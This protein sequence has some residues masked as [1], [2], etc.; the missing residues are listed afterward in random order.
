[1]MSTIIPFARKPL[2]SD[3]SEKDIEQAIAAG[4]QHYFDDCRALVP[5]FVDKH[6]HYP[7]AIKTNRVAWGWDVL[8]APVNLLWAPIYAI[9]C[10]LRFIIPTSHPIQSYLNRVPSGVT[11]RVQRH[12]S[13]LIVRELLNRNDNDRLFEQYLTTS[14]QRLY[15]DQTDNANDPQRFNH[16]I[17]PLIANALTEYQVTRTASADISNSLSC[18]IFGAFAFQKFTP[19][20]IGIAFMLASLWVKKLAVSDFFLG[21]TLGTFYYA[22]FPPTPSLAMTSLVVLGVMTLLS[23]VAALSGVLIDPIQSAVGLHKRRLIRM[24][25]HLQK[26]FVDQTN[27]SYRPKDQFVARIMDAFDMLKSGL[28]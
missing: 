28:G 23:V 3:I 20:G 24:L 4:A 26:D 25:D 9:V 27:S 2:G 18:T 5:T 16:F 7:G 17:K 13:D 6:F 15:H 10:V 11:T 22:L 12:I 21:E 8:I 14:L 1:M 19:G